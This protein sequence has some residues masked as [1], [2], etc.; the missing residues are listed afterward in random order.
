MAYTTMLARVKDKLDIT[1]SDKDEELNEL[2]S[3]AKADLEFADIKKTAIV[4]T[5]TNIQRAILT[6]CMLNYDWHCDPNEY[7]RLKASYDEQKS[8]L[9]MRT[10]YASWTTT[11]TTESG[12]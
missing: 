3:Q 12:S 2:I 4:D 9:K 1:D 10:G 6:Y 11:T 5:D 7:A 8:Q